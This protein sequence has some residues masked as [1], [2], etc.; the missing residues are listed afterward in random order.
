MERDPRE[1]RF[2]VGVGLG[3]GYLSWIKEKDL[4][5]NKINKRAGNHNAKKERHRK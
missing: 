5:S 2:G 4:I 1:R 3:L